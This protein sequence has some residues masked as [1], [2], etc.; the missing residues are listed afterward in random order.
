M[1]TKKR[2]D[3][4]V[5]KTAV[6]IGTAAWADACVEVGVPLQVAPSGLVPVA[7][8]W[9]CEGP[10]VP[11][12]HRGSVD[13]FLEAIEHAP[14]GSVLVVDDRGRDDRACVGDLVTIEAAHA[15]LAGMVVWG[16]HRDTAQLLEIDFPVFSLGRLPNGP[17]GVDPDDGD[18][19]VVVGR[20][21]VARGDLVVGDADGVVVV[22]QAICEAVIDA[23][24]ERVEA[25]DQTSREL[26][27]GVPLAEVYARYGTL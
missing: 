5:D 23:A 10:A 15:G 7:P 24:L 13:V 6:E 9:R 19:S 21:Q 4:P 14:S 8:S 12:R 3:Q 26:A 20:H 27:R 17:L 22:P 2:D 18:V 25:E 11:V 1:G 16:S